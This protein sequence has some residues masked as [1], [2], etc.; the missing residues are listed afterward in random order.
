MRPSELWWQAYRSLLV[1]VCVD[2]N[3]TDIDHELIA[4]EADNACA[5]F[6]KRWG[7]NEDAVVEAEDAWRRKKTVTKP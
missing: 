2:E 6:A 4:K 3:A 5:E 1:G 7:K